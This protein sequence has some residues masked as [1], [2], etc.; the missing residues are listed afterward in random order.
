MW[1]VPTTHARS[2][3]FTPSASWRRCQSVPG[4]RRD[5][6]YAFPHTFLCKSRRHCVEYSTWLQEGESI[7]GEFGVENKW[8]RE[9]SD[10]QVVSCINSFSDMIHDKIRG[11]F[12]LGNACY[13]SVQS[14][15]SPRLLSNNVKM[16]IYKTI[17]LRVVLYGRETWSLTLREKYRPKMFENRVR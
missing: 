10:L 5:G 7:V 4:E 6:D 2:S 11:R 17:L 1:Q 8:V 12:D 16:K 15:L 3:R 14:L 9:G 13:H